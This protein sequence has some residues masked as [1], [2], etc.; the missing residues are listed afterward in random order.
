VANKTNNYKFPK[1][2]ADDFYDISEYNEAM[3]ILDD[4]LMKM[5]QKKLDKNGDA[6]EAVTEFEQEILRENIE[7]GETL[8]S[9]FGK[10]KKWFSEMKDVAFSGHAKDI[11]TD[12]AHRFVSDTEKSGW[13]G[14][15]GASGGDISETVINNLENIEEKFPVLNA[16]E[17][18]KVF[19]GKIKRIIDNT[20][21]LDSDITVHV[22]T[23]GNDTTGNGT[24]LKPFKTIQHAIDIVPN[25]LGGHSAT[26]IVSGGIYSDDILI[27]GFNN[28][29][30]FEIVFAGDVTVG[31]VTIDSSNIVCRSIDTTSRKFI[32]K[33]LF[34]TGSG[35]FD[36]WVTVDITTTEYIYNPPLVGH[37]S[38][39]AVNRGD[40]Y[41]SG[42]T[43][44]TGNI[45]TG[46]YVVSISR[47]YFGNITGKGLNIGMLV[48]T[49]SQISCIANNI[50]ASIP[51]SHFQGG[52]F[53]NENGTQISE[54]ITSGLS[55]SWGAILGGYVRHGNMNG[56]AMV[57]INIRVYVTSALSTGGAKYFI[58]GFPTTPHVPIAVS[59]NVEGHF[60]YRQMDTT[61]TIYLI[62]AMAIP[63]GNVYYLSATYLTNS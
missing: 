48:S 17:T 6:S 39:I 36:S 46:V 26:I 44:I 13:N 10:V 32:I 43:T 7:S 28:N 60:S 23:E 58:Y 14:K 34:V 2:E 56:P 4:S 41:I 15:V 11:T 51:R 5:D 63:V 16:G 37:K 19:I 24:S 1:P 21:P 35:R 20:K 59:C 31:S 25:D 52:M 61:G 54:L 8:S 9:T 49:S 27:K 57:T 29:G 62:P 18:T 12:A 50:S 53:I 47:A 38:S 22:N 3:D 55:C 45:D 33:Y 30:L 40:I 42:N